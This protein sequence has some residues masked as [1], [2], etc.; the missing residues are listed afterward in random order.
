MTMTLPEGLAPETYPLAW[1]VGTW[2]GFGELA[3][4]GIDAT[5]VLHDIT[6]DHDGGPYLRQVWTIWSTD[7]AGHAALRNDATGAVNVEVGGAEGYGALTPTQ[8]W[9]TE[10]TYW[11]VLP[12]AAPAPEGAG[13]DAIPAS[14]ELVSADP[15]GHVG[16]WTGSVAGPRIEVSSQ[17]VCATPQAAQVDS[18][19]RFFGLVNSEL[20][21]VSYLAAFG[22]E[23]SP[24]FSGR[25]AR[26]S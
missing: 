25:L 5:L 19:R 18:M 4:P 11:R 24:Y 20:M 17:C 9:S 16:T 2:R 6:F 3:Y 13:T 1:L 22:N 14:L 7:P 8:I 12:G 26:V 21:V 23:E 10:T 15:A